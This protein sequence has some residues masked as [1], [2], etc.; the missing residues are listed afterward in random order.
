MYKSEEIETQCSGLY[1]LLRLAQN[2]SEKQVSD[3]VNLYVQFID[4]MTEF[5]KTPMLYIMKNSK[6]DGG[7]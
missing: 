2:P 6:K 3:A 1:S 7:G 4:K 5:Q